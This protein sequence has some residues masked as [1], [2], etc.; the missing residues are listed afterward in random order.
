ML[1]GFENPLICSNFCKAISLKDK[2]IFYYFLFIWRQLYDN[3][4]FFGYEGKTSGIKNFLFDDFVSFY[5]ITIPP[6]KLLENFNKIVFPLFST[7]IKNRQENANLTQLRDFLL[8]L[9]M[10][11]QVSVNNVI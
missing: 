5:E 9:L 1:K 3:R 11:G 8:P 4:L 10:N 6:T 7:I 2:K